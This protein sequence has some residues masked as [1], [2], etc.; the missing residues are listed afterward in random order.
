M[1][2]ARPL[3]RLVLLAGAVAIG[4]LLFRAAPREVNLVYGLQGSS[5]RSLEIDIEKDG[6]T[7]RH[8]EFRFETGAPGS[9]SHRVRL[10]DGRYVLR[11]SLVSPGG[12]RRVE[13]PIQVSESGTIVIPLGS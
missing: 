3:A 12:T 7:V 5:A 13:R 10:T 4:L 1:T 11:A 8:A 9:V 2:G 6:Q